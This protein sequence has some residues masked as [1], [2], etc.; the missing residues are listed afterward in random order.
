ML[1]LCCNIMTGIIRT[2]CVALG[3]LN[4]VTCQTIHDSADKTL[5]RRVFHKLFNSLTLAPLWYESV[6]WNHVGTICHCDVTIASD[7]ILGRHRTAA[8]YF[9]SVK[10]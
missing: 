2:V 3:P 9:A 5:N 1:P 10:P 8:V 4:D 7:R 6:H